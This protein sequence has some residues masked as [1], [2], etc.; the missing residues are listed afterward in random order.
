[1]ASKLPKSFTQTTHLAFAAH[2]IPFEGHEEDDD[3][4]I[5]NIAD[6]ERECPQLV[7]Q[8]R[9]IAGGE[10]YERGVQAERERLKAL[11]SLSSPGREAIIDKAKYQ[12]PKD[13]RDIAIELLQADKNALTRSEE[14][15][16]G[17]ECRSRWS[18]YH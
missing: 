9:D 17:K 3:L 12:E 4:K 16:V 1:M 14:R 7:A 10:G 15:R 2:E 11:D 18:P 6:L 8:I 5:E 13:A